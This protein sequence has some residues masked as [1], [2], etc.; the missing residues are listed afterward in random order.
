MPGFFEG[1]TLVIASMHRKEVVL[2][3]LLKQRLKTYR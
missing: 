2:K 3:P 1:R